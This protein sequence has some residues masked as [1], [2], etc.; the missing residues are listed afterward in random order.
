LSKKGLKR[1][2]VPIFIPNQGCRHRCIFCEQER[3]TSQSSRSLTRIDV[4]A[5]LDRA[6][7]SNQF[8]LRRNPEVAFF[9]GTFTGLPEDTFRGLLEAVA[10]YI[11]RGHFQSI[12]VSTRPDTL[13]EGRLEMMKDYGVSTVEL[14]AQCMDDRV[15]TLS[16]RG[17]T[18]ED[19]VNGVRTLREYG[20]KVGIQL[21]P[22]LPGDST[23][24]FRSTITRVIS[25]H[26]DMVRLYPA[27]VIR[28]TELAVWYREKRFHPLSLEEAIEICA[29]SCMRLEAE[30]IPVIR[31]GLMS[32]PSLLQKGQIIA[33]PWHP[34][35]GSLVRSRVYQKTIEPGLPRRGQFS[36]MKIYAPK[37]AIPLLRGHK[38]QGL[39]WIENK[40]G[41]EVIEV[42]CD[43]SLP[44]WGLRT[45]EI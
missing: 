19:T 3:I 13:D 14:G 30:K 34:S 15:L 43:D 6:I 18:A 11:E 25:L 45:E 27:L 2:I 40:T 17:H 36:R 16:G 20:F 5:I 39:K 8:D 7:L 21:L 10:P 29:E 37:R 35:F 1:L 33:G 4:K 44:L 12:R 23:E 24:A 28:G 31:M 32:S 38:N 22:G 42:I 41:S 9:G 26:P